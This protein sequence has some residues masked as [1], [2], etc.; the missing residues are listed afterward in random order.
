MSL[1]L[2][3]GS[4]IHSCFIYSHFPVFMRP[5]PSLIH[6]C[7][8][9]TLHEN[10]I[11]P[12]P[13]PGTRL[14]KW[15]IWHRNSPEESFCLIRETLQLCLSPPPFLIMA[16]LFSQMLRPKLS[17]TLYP[18]CSSSFTSISKA[19]CSKSNHGSPFLTTTA[20]VP[21][22]VI[23]CLDIAV[24]SSLISQLPSCLTSLFSTELNR[25]R[26]CHSPA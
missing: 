8:P 13:A 24:A 6:I 20:L 11:P 19:V 16:G 4:V 18:S 21:V 12:G 3:P 25:I 26:S 17:A 5:F 22:P 7:T 10:L 9:Q 1:H 14:I 23:S 2:G 15:C